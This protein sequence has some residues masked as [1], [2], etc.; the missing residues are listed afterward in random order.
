MEGGGHA[1]RIRC[2]IHRGSHGAMI[3]LFIAQLVRDG[4]RASTPPRSRLTL[5]RLHARW[6]GCAV[7]LFQTILGQAINKPSNWP[8]PRQTVAER[9]P[10]RSTHRLPFLLAG[11]DYESPRGRHTVGRGADG[12]WLR[13]QHRA[14]RW[15]RNAGI[16]LCCRY[17]PANFSLARR[18]RPSVAQILQRQGPSAKVASPR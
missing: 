17:P 13:R 18:Q 16:E 7:L 14:A 15:Y 12:Y 11:V 5:W 10:A 9:R 1:A 3:G 8:S 6:Q 2:Y 4:E